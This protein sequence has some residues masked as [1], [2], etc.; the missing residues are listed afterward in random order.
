MI[1]ERRKKLDTM[2]KE[3]KNNNKNV[4]I[5]DDT[6]IENKLSEGYLLDRLLL[7][8]TPSGEILNDDIINEEIRLMLFT[9]SANFVK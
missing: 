8:K 6:F 5:N 3:F 1:A 4:D 9:V 7:T 2:L